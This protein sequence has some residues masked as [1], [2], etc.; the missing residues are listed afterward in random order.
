VLPSSE[1]TFTEAH[2]AAAPLARPE[3]H[4]FVV[5]ECDQPHAGCARHSLR[6]VRE[7]VIGRGACREA[8]REGDH[9][10]LRLP[11]GWL[12]KEHAR[13]ERRG[14]GWWIEDLSSRNGTR[15]NGA[16]VTAQALADQ[17]VIEAG[18]TLIL[19]REALHAPPHAMLDVDADSAPL[20]EIGLGTVIPGIAD[21]VQELAR[22]AP[23][24]LPVLLRGETGTGKEVVARALHALSKRSGPFVAVNCGGI[25]DTLI[26]SQLFGHVKGAFS[27]AV[28]DEPGFVRASSGGTLFLDEVGDLPQSCQT[29]LLR[30]L[31]ESEVVPVGASRP[32]GVQLR[33]VAATHQPLEALIARGLFRAD[34]LARLDGFSFALLPLRSRREDL[35]LLVADLFGAAS[36][37]A[38]PRLSIDVGRALLRYSWPLNIRELQHCLARAT[39]LIGMGDAIELRHLPEAIR[40][41][42][43]SSV[44]APL[45]PA[46]STSDAELRARVETLLAEHH[47]NISEVARATGKGRMQIHR[48]LKRLAIDPDRYRT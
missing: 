30:V 26:E 46:H 28:R 21:D 25:P 15:V 10:M 43:D 24:M 22:I 8:V 38:P 7:A 2:G 31:Q 41:A 23:T 4:L 37:Q 6:G 42:A 9:L 39:A 36:P 32:V 29:A 33:V 47:G 11:G 18:H 5:L 16:L 1:G 44:V 3:P 14:S 45:R 13:V 48:W 27:G 40:K 17:D 20:R 12:S 35:G 34:L 19:F